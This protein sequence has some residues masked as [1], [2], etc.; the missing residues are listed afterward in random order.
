[1]TFKVLNSIENVSV[2]QFN[3]THPL[4]SFQFLKLL[5]DSKSVDSQCGWSPIV[6]TQDDSL[7]CAYIKMHSYGEY[8]FDWAW[9]DLYKRVGVNYYPKLLHAIPFT[10][11]NSPKVFSPTKEFLENIR[12]FYLQDNSLSSHHYLFTTKELGEHLSALGYFKK[13]T[14]Q[15][16]FEN[17]FSSFEDFLSSLKAR[18]RKKVKKE[19][20]KVQDLD[21][22]IERV[23]LKDLTQDQCLEV[24]E[25]YLT[26]I[27][28]KYSHPYL[29]QDFFKG[30]NKLTNGF[31]FFAK[32]IDG[33]NIAMSLFFYSENVLYGRYWGTKEKN[34]LLH[35]E[36]CYYLGIEFCIKNN[37]PLFEAGAQGEQKLLRGFK[38][39]I[40]ESWHHIRQPELRKII[41]DHTRIENINIKRQ[42][43]N[44]SLYLP[45]KAYETH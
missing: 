15:F 32:N 6:F 11:V 19:R 26:T 2:E 31:V 38:P 13:E 43:E 8:I 24:Y 42:I 39:V 14:L 37:I 17:Q 7:S 18:K 44:L 30:L 35:F 22:S 9:A 27:D 23:E 3:I 45:Y 4:A 41:E 21:V 16:H 1:M 25:L 29:N 34:D 12:E 5:E 20:R 40:I 28:K 10:P 36:M 33:H